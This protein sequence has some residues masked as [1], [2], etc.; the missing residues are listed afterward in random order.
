MLRWAWVV[1]IVVALLCAVR[2]ARA[3]TWEVPLGARAVSLGEGRVACK[4]PP[5]EAGWTTDADGRTLRPP[6]TDGEGKLVTVKVAPTTAGCATSTASLMVT[7]T[8]LR[9]TVDTLTVDVDG[10]RILAQGHKLRGAVLRWTAGARNGS[11]VCVSPET[12]PQ[13]ETCAFS[14]PR[15]LPADVTAIGVDVFPAGTHV[16][17]GMLFF[18]SQGRPTPESAFEVRPTEITIHELVPA[19]VSVDLSSGTGTVPF[20]HPE[21]VASVSCVDAACNLEGKGFVVRSER[22]SDDQLDVHIQLR[23]HVMF[24]S[25][26]VPDTAPT[27]AIP[28]QR[29]PV[30]IASAAVISGGD[31]E[32]I[33]VRVEGSCAHA[34]GELSIA[35]GEGPARVERRELIGG[36]LF[37]VARI[38]RVE[39]DSLLVTVRR[40]GTILGTARSEA[41][42]MAW[43]A[44]LEL[45]GVGT[46]DFIPTNRWARVK[47]PQ[48]PRGTAAE[49]RAV[50]GVYEAKHDDTGEFWVR[51]ADGASGSAPLRLA[52]VDKTL[53]GPLLGLTLAEGSEP[54]DR[55]IRVA[56]VPV[57]LGPAVQQKDPLIELVC[58]NGEGVPSRVRAGTTAQI[59][60]RAR[61]TCQLVFH[62]ERLAPE[63]GAQSLQVSINVTGADGGAKSDARVDQRLVL[64]HDTKPTT[65]AI[66]GATDPFDRISVRIGD[67]PGALDEGDRADKQAPQTQWSVVTGTSRGRLYGTTAIPTGLFRV[68]DEGHSGILTLSVGAILRAV[69]LSRDGTAFP[70]GVEAGVM[71]LGIAGDTPPQA[72]SGGEVAVVAGLGVA[73][74]IANA[75]HASQTAISV[76]A[77]VEYEVSRTILNQQGSPLGFVFGPSISIGDVGTNF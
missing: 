24:R 9:P 54:V 43:R 38:A 72:A 18:D 69:L 77:W 8:G 6:P 7:A 11:D 59:P 75:T 13:G 55:T 40:R 32:R 68:A 1:A 73:V 51:G 67:A 71:W 17:D 22:G 44:R 57:A 33:V 45:D 30:A 74:P 46:I 14:T 15:D 41:R 53:P 23:A 49:V 35:T 62:R 39:G 3:E 29:C 2:P 48:A 76:H 25:N 52:V 12:G 16:A 70:L 31:D 5:L 42:R 4:D 63:D 27:I 36:A 56:N 28:L 47:V 58:G 10:G 19:D 37:A 20:V 34:E 66:T 21:A 64:R 26:G 60:Y 65:L 50:D 61:D